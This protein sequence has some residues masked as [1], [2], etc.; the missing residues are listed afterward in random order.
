M[1]ETDTRP[2]PN[3]FNR[4]VD[5]HGY[6]WWAVGADDNPPYTTTVDFITAHPELEHIT[7]QEL[8]EARGPLR[9]VELVPEQDVAVLHEALLGAGTKAMGSVIVA[10]HTTALRLHQEHGHSAA[11]TA[12]RP[13]SWESATVRNLCWEGD[14]IKGS[15]V[16]EAACALLADTLHRWATG[17][18]AVEVAENLSNVL[19]KVTDEA[20]G[21]SKVTDQW[22]R[23]SLYA[24]R[25]YVWA[26]H[27]A[28]D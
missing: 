19:E 14:S 1:T 8:Q 23:R 15:R 7:L 2:A 5:A 27:R 28:M 18:P 25:L 4:V 12:G 13:G 26:L 24:E 3:R 6:G 10:L 21:W 22:L 9:N 11:L 20:G 16:D 17:D